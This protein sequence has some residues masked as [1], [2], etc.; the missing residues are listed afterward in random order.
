MCSTFLNVCQ[1]IHLFAA[2]ASGKVVCTDFLEQFFVSLFF[3]IGLLKL[4]KLDRIKM[5]WNRI[6]EVSDWLG[7]L[8]KNE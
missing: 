6:D 1:C 5:T 2:E 4:K 3:A 8:K 7:K